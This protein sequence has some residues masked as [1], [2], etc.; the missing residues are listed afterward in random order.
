MSHSVPK[1]A[2]GALANLVEEPTSECVIPWSLDPKVV[3]AV[4]R[5][6]AEAWV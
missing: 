4:A 6:T 1:A 2:A 3:P 5:A